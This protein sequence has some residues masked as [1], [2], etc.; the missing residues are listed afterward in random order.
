MKPYRLWLTAPLTK[1]MPINS[2]PL[3]FSRRSLLGTARRP[4]A[5]ARL[6]PARAVA[7]VDCLEPQLGCGRAGAP[8]GL[9]TALRP[10]LPGVWLSAR[11][12]GLGCQAYPLASAY[13]FAAIPGR[14]A[15]ELRQWSEA[16]G[17]EPHPSRVKYSEAMT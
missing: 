9:C 4:H 13:A 10:G 1:P 6:Y 12:A 8:L 16:A 5:L 11:R 15:L 3:R 7:G 14:Y 17:L 2:E